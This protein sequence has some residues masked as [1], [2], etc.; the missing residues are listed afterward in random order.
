VTSLALLKFRTVRLMN[1]SQLSGRGSA[2]SNQIESLLNEH[3][4]ARI[5][6]W[7][8]HCLASGAVFTT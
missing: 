5:G 8:V 4:V 6:I 2:A 7:C 1:R 3:D